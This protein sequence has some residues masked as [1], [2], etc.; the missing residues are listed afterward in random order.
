MFVVKHSD[1]QAFLK[2]INL[3]ILVEKYIVVIKHL[4]LL[5]IFKDMN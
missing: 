3:F 4:Q 2:D 1:S 5:V